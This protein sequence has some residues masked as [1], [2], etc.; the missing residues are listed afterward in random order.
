MKLGQKIAIAYIRAHLALLAA[1]STKKA[2]QKAFRLFCTPMRKTK[3]I[4]T[5]VFDEAER[6]SVTVDGLTVNGFRWNRGGHPRLQVVH[7]FESASQNFGVYIKTFIDK[8]YE[9]LAFDAP[10]HG[11]SCGKQITL[12][13]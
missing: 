10:A 2:A 13:L 6:L 1:L 5:P 8:G 9:V 4:V 12:P 7:G 11:V 3:K